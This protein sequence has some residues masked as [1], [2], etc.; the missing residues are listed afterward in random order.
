MEIS[1]SYESVPTCREFSDDDSFIRGIMGP[2]G[3]IAP[4]TRVMTQE[5]AIPISDID[6]PTLVLSWNE[7]LGRFEY[8]PTGGA[9]PKGTDYLYRV[10]TTQGEWSAAGFHRVFC[11]ESSYRRVD[12]LRVGDVIE[13]LPALRQKRNEV[14]PLSSAASVPSLREKVLD[15]LGGYAKSARRYGQR[16]LS[17]TGIDQSFFPLPAGVQTLSRYGDLSE[18]L[19]EGVS[20]QTPERTRR[21]QSVYLLETGGSHS[22][23]NPL[24]DGAGGRI[25]EQFFSRHYDSGQSVW[26]FLR[27][28][29]DRQIIGSLFR[30]CSTYIQ[31]STKGVI[32]SIEREDIK[33][34]YWDLQ[35]LDNH[36]YV[37]EDGS[38]HH[39][40]GKSSACVWEII[41]RGI[42]QKPGPDGIARSR[43]IIVRNSYVQ[44][45]DTTIRTVFDW[46]PPKQFGKYRM[47]DHQYMI[48]AFPN[49]EIELLFRSLDRPDHVSNLLSLEATG[50]WLNECR[51]CPQEIFEAIQGRV[52]R[53][54]SKRN[55][56]C[57]WFGIILDTN[58]PDSD[59]WYYKLAEEIR[60]KNAR[61][62]KQPSGL[63][64]AAENL[65]H[66]PDNYYE[67]LA[68]GK[69]P[70][71]V[72]IYVHGEYGFIIDG[73]PVYPEYQDTIHCKDLQPIKGVPIRRGW[74][75]GLT[76][77]VSFT[78]M[79]PNGQWL[80][81]DEMVSDNTGVDRFSD[82]VL[83]YCATHYGEFV[84]QDFGD[85]AGTQRSQTDEKTCFQILQAKQIWIEPGEQDPYIRV[86]SVK[87]AL[88]TMIEGEPGM[89]L[90]PKAKTLRKGFRG[91]Y[92]YRRMQTANRQFTE[93]PE[94]NEY[95]HCFADGTMVSVP[96][97]WA[98]IEDIS[99]GDLVN[100]PLGPRMVTKT[101]NR[102]ADTISLDLGDRRITCTPD[103]PFMGEDG[104]VRADA[105]KYAV[106]ETDRVTESWVDLQNMKYNISRVLNT[107][108]SQRGTINPIITGMVVGIYIGWYGKRIMGRFLKGI[109]STTRTMIARTTSL[110]TWN[111]CRFL[112][113]PAT[114]P[115]SELQT[116]IS[117]YTT[118]LRQPERRQENGMD[119]KR[120]LSGTLNTESEH[121]RQGRQLR[122]P[123]R[124][125]VNRIKPLFIRKGIALRSV[126][127]KQGEIREQMMRRENVLSVVRVLWSTVTPK[128]EHAPSR[129]LKVLD[130]KPL[131]KRTVYD[132]TVEDA[133][134]F[135][136]EGVLVHNCHDALQYD[137]TR[138]FGMVLKTPQEQKQTRRKRHNILSWMTA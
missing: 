97:G 2:F 15:Y 124:F 79:A 26:R 14:F 122:H 113:M 102:V 38:I 104:L 94:K 5:G 116:E 13:H 128:R 66:L 135:Y 32:I 16:L 80:I 62:Y 100:T 81:L 132:L 6:Q 71:F 77:A 51:E 86:E 138:L 111:V 47:T 23:P 133:H 123:A 136:A 134:C 21:G 93:K 61:F 67:N 31:S 3:C 130:K 89:L 56:G 103:H 127:P 50:A 20:G 114:T 4:E 45:R 12:E 118:G 57:T 90:D 58:P 137:A 48:T 53:Y 18:S 78:Q 92:K 98:R 112:T 25:G 87:K 40:S 115:I 43:W 108:A 72:K 117:L 54:P 110:A 121:G 69:D 65:V 24:Y 120:G 96:S 95:S 28:F 68:E 55:G 33:R 64:P 10:T 27:N 109:A 41:Q 29:V 119:Q 99:V 22:R 7:N 125:V 126:K 70:E 35:V 36:N 82:A 30:R 1:Y 73:K 34:E 75:F 46:L 59:S 17:G 42:A 85:P 131:G 129:A 8:A 76:P 49:C 105:L 84:F 19:H 106:T 44:L 60:P 37:I 9:F 11:G 74:D 39:N 107:I 88:N 52:G 63:S 91:G 101:M 83:R